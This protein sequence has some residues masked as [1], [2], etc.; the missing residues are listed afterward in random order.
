MPAIFVRVCVE[1]PNN[2]SFTLTHDIYVIT[3]TTLC[4]KVS[5]ISDT[6]AVVHIITHLHSSTI[7]TRLCLVSLALL[8]AATSAFA[9]P[10]PAFSRRAGVRLYED[11]DDSATEAVFVPPEQNDEASLEA[12]ESLGRGAAKVSSCSCLTS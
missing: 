2:T 1:R 5:A 10:S 9:P 4:N 6:I 12:V 8:V 11:K 7:M 3:L